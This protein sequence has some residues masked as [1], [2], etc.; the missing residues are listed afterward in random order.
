MTN[1]QAIKLDKFYDSLIETNKKFNLTRITAYEDVWNK[2]FLDCLALAPYIP[3]GAHIIDVG[4]G[5]GFPA[6]PLAI[7][8][9]DIQITAIDSLNKRVNFVNEVACELE[10][11]NLTCIHARAE[12]LAHEPDFREQFDIATSRAVADL[13]ILAEYCLP[14][15]KIGGKMLAMKSA[16]IEEELANA[17][18]HIAL[19]GGS[20]P[21][22]ETYQIADF[23]HS[24]VI[25]EKTTP[26]PKTYPRNAKKILSLRA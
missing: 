3:Q 16:G 22:K 15:V 21:K 11:K 9:D 12:Q 14:F 26:T 2:H 5:A 4:T 17:Q 20:P 6:I 25:V 1:E 19:L 13:R 24:I 18:A 8:R 10:L 23:S 7:F